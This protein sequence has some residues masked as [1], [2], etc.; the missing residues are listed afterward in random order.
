MILE[1]WSRGRAA[2]IGTSL[3]TAALLAT[4]GCGDEGLTCGTGTEAK[5]GKCMAKATTPAGATLACGTG[6]VEKEGK[7][8]P[9][10][11]GATLKCGAG[12][13]E[14]DGQC[15]APTPGAVVTCGPGTMEKEGKCIIDVF[16]LKPKVSKV[17]VKELI[18]DGDETQPIMVLHP[19]QVSAQ[20]EVTGESFES[21]VVVGLRN[22]DG[23]KNCSLGFWPLEHKSA[24]NEADTK[25]V[26]AGTKAFTA[27]YKLDKDFFA[28]PSCETL[29]GEKD[30]ATW[31]AFD[32]FENTNYAERKAA[33]KILDKATAGTEP[34]D[35]KTPEQLVAKLL[36]DNMQ[37]LTNC[38]AGPTSTHPDTCVTKMTVVKSAGIDLRME[39]MSLNKSVVVFEFVG[40]QPPDVP[41]S[42]VTV[43][44]QKIQIPALDWAK[45]KP[46]VATTPALY[47]N[48]RL[49]A[50]GLKPE[51]KDKFTNDDFG[52]TFQI[53]PVGAGSEEWVAMTEKVEQA[54]KAGEEPTVEYLEKVFLQGLVAE[55][56]YI[57]ESPIYF[58]QKAKDAV[59][60]GKWSNQAYFDIRICADGPFTEGGVDADPKRNN[61][62]V[63]QFV[64]IRNQRNYVKTPSDIGAA[65]SKPG[66]APDKTGLLLDE[67]GPGKTFGDPNRVALEMKMK[68]FR[69]WDT[70]TRKMRIGGLKGLYV[71]GWFPVTIIE[72]KAWL[73]IATKA[74][75]NVSGSFTIFNITLPLPSLE[76]P[77]AWEY[78][79]G[80]VKHKEDDDSKSVK[81]KPPLPGPMKALL[82]K[83]EEALKKEKSWEK[84]V[85]YPI[86]G[87]LAV[88]VGIGVGLSAWL[89]MGVK[90]ETIDET[91]A[92]CDAIHANYCYRQIK[93]KVVT[94]DQAKKICADKGGRLASNH[95]Q[96][97]NYDA[98][99]ALA[100]K[101]GSFWNA[102]RAADK[103]T[104]ATDGGDNGWVPQKLNW[105][106]ANSINTIG[107]C[108][109]TPNTA[110]FNMQKPNLTVP[111]DTKLFSFPCH[112]A[113][114]V[115]CEFAKPVPNSES[116][117]LYAV[118]E[119]N[120]K[121]DATGSAGLSLGVI[122]GGIYV[123]IDL[124]KGALPLEAGIK[125]T[126]A[127]GSPNAEGGMFVRLL[128]EISTL[129]GE[130]G[131]WY[132]WWK[133]AW[134]WCW[135]DRHE[136][137]LF[138]WKGFESKMTLMETN[139]GGFKY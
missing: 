69:Q 134:C 72:Q 111:Y 11:A 4:A 105:T 22:A 7:C 96:Q 94:F 138:G 32:P 126:S 43:A 33:S 121:V 77:E 34:A 113:T 86:A 13:S 100:D 50:F 55:T 87:P 95:G 128:L 120:F 64:L 20:I 110:Y 114:G 129:N 58:T 81:V 19:V 112:W 118:I 99:N 108:G 48:T 46:P 52:L 40:P 107:V 103:T 21:M 16:A 91:E 54:S 116:N 73:E 115:V 85:S 89:E 63:Q 80:G 98:L 119:P 29:I 130:I 37:P 101:V 76:T 36:D 15:V 83:L 84:F 9:A 45:F 26:G 66:A 18:V 31:V 17:T 90:K 44:G 51:S 53:R 2:A 67:F 14:K 78:M 42:E 74:A 106:D 82:K 71:R 88:T 109:L 117:E 6:T 5:D 97:A 25:K 27:T 65:P 122:Q 35:K 133:V 123:K 41:A 8:I 24:A 59:V 61:C 131:P 125:W 3:A 49:V 1:N 70:D 47:V 93:D 23:S 104:W 12:T 60:T 39:Q 10:A 68:V 30:L 57:K 92:S 62:E 132:Q 139:F 137:K 28:Q 124:V 79:I 38:K 136:F 56:R 127:G 102:V 135:G 75:D